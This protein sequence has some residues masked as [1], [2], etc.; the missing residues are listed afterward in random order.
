M[1]TTS[2]LLQ[3][4]TR[5][6]LSLLLCASIFIQLL[7]RELIVSFF[8]Y[9][10]KMLWILVFLSLCLVFTRLSISGLPSLQLSRER[11]VPHEKAAHKATN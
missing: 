5:G 6:L 11:I 8:C 3:A 10:K 7:V 1:K 9:Q 4:P 2:L